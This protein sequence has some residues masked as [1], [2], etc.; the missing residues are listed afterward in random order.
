MEGVSVHFLP[1]RFDILDWN[2]KAVAS[3]AFNR[4]MKSSG[5]RSR[6]LRTALFKLDVLTPQNCEV[7]VEHDASLADEIDFAGNERVGDDALSFWNCHCSRTTYTERLAAQ[8][9]MGMM[10]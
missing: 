3:S 10:M 6:F 5:N 2:V 9:R 4:N 1:A 8:M 7:S